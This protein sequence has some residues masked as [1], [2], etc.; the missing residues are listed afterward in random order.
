MEIK[1]PRE[2]RKYHEAIFFGLSIRQFIC[3]VVAIGVSV[4]AYFYLKDFLGTEGVT[5]IC[6]FVAF[7]TASLGFIT[8]HGMNLENFIWAYLKSE[9]L[10]PKRLIFASDNYMYLLYQINLKTSKKGRN[11][12]LKR[13]NKG[14]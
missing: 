4:V 1:I 2:V 5:W 10:M 11:K 9:W 14:E 7:P 12:R 3:S 13:K 8:Y 6:V